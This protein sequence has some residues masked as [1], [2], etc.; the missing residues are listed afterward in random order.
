MIQSSG[1]AVG[2]SVV[3]PAHNEEKVIEKTLVRAVEVLSGA[4]P[5]Y[6]IILVDDGSQDRTGD[7]ADAIARMNP[8]VRIIHNRPQRG[9]GGALLAGFSAASKDLLFFMDSD[10]Q[11]DIEEIN[12][13]IPFA[14]QGYRAVLGYR[15]PRRDPFVRLLN[16]WGWNRLIRLLF[17]V[18]IGDIDCAFKLYDRALVQSLD[19][20]AQGATINAEMV[21]KLQRLGVPFAEVPVTHYPRVHGTA[22]GADIR[23]I[24]RAFRE[25]VRLRGELRTWA[26][27]LPEAPIADVVLAADSSDSREPAMVTFTG[28]YSVIDA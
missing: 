14:L 9:Y 28:G 15:A 23:V 5:D 4:A 26:P 18:R 17:G 27:V 19:V 20:N 12:R 21:I 2:I 22:S 13:L 24:M 25:L 7:I 16:A 8:R 6:E 3:M 11:F 1:D 10:G